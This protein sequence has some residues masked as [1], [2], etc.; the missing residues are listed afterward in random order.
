MCLVPA[1]WRV[2]EAGSLLGAALAGQGASAEAEAILLE[3]Y[4]GR[5]IVSLY[6]AW[7]KPAQADGWRARDD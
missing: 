4:G 1:H 6:E 2:A 7:G 3:S 5:R